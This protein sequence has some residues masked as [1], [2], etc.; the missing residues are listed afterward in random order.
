MK[1]YTAI[2]KAQFQFEIDHLAE[3]KRHNKYVTR[4]EDLNMKENFI[5]TS[6]QSK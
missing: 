1:C 2:T 3:S 6:P 5:R 4:E